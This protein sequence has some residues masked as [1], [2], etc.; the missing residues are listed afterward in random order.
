MKTKTR[1]LRFA[2][3]ATLACGL[4]AQVHAA[5][6]IYAD[7]FSG[8]S[9]TNLSGL[10]PDTRPGTETWNTSTTEGA[11]KADG[12]MPVNTGTDLNGNRNAFLP[13]T[14]LLSKVY[15]LSMT[16]NVT[17]GDSDWFALGFAELGATGTGDQFHSQN[18][19]AWILQRH[20]GDQFPDDTFSGPNAN[21]GVNHIFADGPQN[22]KIVLDTT[23]ALWT[24]DFFRND[25]HLRE[26]T[27]GTNPTI[28]HVGFSKFDDASGTVDNFSLTV[29]PEPSAAL[30][31]GLG[32]LALLRRRR[33]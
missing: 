31:G 6:T 8:T 24:V 28:N 18:T 33:R 29:I 21:G 4:Y 23:T 19:T 1:F 17:A 11:W 32:M 9:G 12:S 7:D 26:F 2:S 14:P 15:T 16:V 13:F 20:K 3:L 30:L 25:V 10:A 22:L 5:T 27:Y